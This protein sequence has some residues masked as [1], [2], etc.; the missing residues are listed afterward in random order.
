VLRQLNEMASKRDGVDVAGMLAMTPVG[1][2]VPG[3]IF[4]LM[5]IQLI[6]GR[7]EPVLPRFIMTRRLPTKQLLS[8]AN[9][10][11]ASAS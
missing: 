7:A 8:P 4:A 5:T 11:I 6:V 2:T 10:P 3:L 1:S 9:A